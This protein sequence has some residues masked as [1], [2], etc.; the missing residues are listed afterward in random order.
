MKKI[1]IM[2]N[3][4]V[5]IY[6]SRKELVEQL[7]DEGF[8]VII[9][10]PYGERIDDLIAI[11]CGYSEISM[12]R[13]GTNIIEEM[14]LL[15]QYFK[16]IS[17]IKPNAVLT[18][19]IKPNIY[20]GIVCRFKKIPYIAN[21][22]GLGTAVDNNGLMQKLT[23]KLYKI[24]FKR[25]N[26]VFFQNNENLMFFN[27]KKIAIHK[28]KLIPG[29][30]VNLE[31]FH[32]QEYPKDDSVEFV[33]ISRIMREKG[34]DLYLEAARYIREMYPNTVFHI[35]GFCEEAYEEKLYEMQHK[36]IIIYH[37]MIR[38]V[39]KIL[40]NIHCLIHPTFYPEGLSNVL[41]EGAASARPII[42]TNR[43]GCRE[44]VVNGVNGYLIEEKSTSELIEKIE[45]FLKLSYEEKKRMG[46]EGRKKVQAEYD[47]KIV[48]N[49][50]WEELLRIC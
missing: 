10:S 20:G 30:G 5:A 22:T 36:G 9:S 42:T 29:S 33:F 28:G 45:L 46:I 32:L 18:F 21:I 16:L 47:R 15:F 3:H 26:C 34:I 4:D 39:R 44:V 12:N 14:V 49:K 38:D 13:H 25:I 27:N 19:T 40:S 17:N 6:N 50:Y 23:V 31:Y 48:V 37:G 35:C 24:A 2:V 7:L 1:L 41:L 43:A 8:E 11:G